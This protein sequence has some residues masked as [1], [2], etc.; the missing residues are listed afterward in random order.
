[1]MASTLQSQKLL[2]L[3]LPRAESSASSWQT[4]S[5]G[6]GVVALRVLRATDAD[7]RFRAGRLPSMLTAAIPVYAMTI[8]VLHFKRDAANARNAATMREL[9]M[10]AAPATTL[11]RCACSAGVLLAGG[12]PRASDGVQKVGA[13]RCPGGET[14]G[15]QSG[16][17][18]HHIR[19]HSPTCGVCSHWRRQRKMLTAW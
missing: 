17:P 7:N 14:A 5:A 19:R 8:I 16:R 10:P 6:C 9:P 3:T 11:R 15:F 1:M 13:L 18:R 2:E 12:I 4:Q